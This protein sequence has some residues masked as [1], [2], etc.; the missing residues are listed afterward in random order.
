[1]DLT[2]YDQTSNGISQEQHDLIEKVLQ[3]AAKKLDLAD[4]TEMSVTLMNNPEIKKINA[5]Y[6]GVD[7]ATDVLSFA[8][9]ESGDESPIIMDPELAAELPTNLG[10]LFIS[11]DKVAEQAKFLG[12]SSERELGF[13]AIHGFLHL[14]GYD[15]QQLEDEKKMFALQREILDDYGLTR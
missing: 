3:F 2:I 12:H 6:R 7:R 8:A 4:N 13:L 15:H 14:N 11:V 1:M 10:D 9:E 5:Q